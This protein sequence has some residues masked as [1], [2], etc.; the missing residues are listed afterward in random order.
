MRG[1][2][3]W[4]GGGEA[5]TAADSNEDYRNRR[6]KESSTSCSRTW[7][8]IEKKKKVR[9]FICSFFDVETAMAGKVKGKGLGKK[10]K[11]FAI[12]NQVDSRERDGGFS[13][14]FGGRREKIS[15]R[16]KSFIPLK[17]KQF[18]EK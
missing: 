8:R 6:G 7:K 18:N 14:F 9:A 5:C 17:K 11:C 10:R 2:G 13:K 3:V 15:P 1:M 16:A 4:E 12:T